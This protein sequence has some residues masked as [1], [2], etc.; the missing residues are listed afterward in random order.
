MCVW[1]GVCILLCNWS[2]VASACNSLKRGFGSW[3]EIAVWP[4]CWEHRILATRLV[5]SNKVL[6]LQLCKKGIPTKTERSETSQVLIRRRRV[7]YVRIDTGGL[8]ELHSRGSLNHFYGHFFQVS[9]GQS[10]FIFKYL[11]ICLCWVLVAA[12]RIFVAVRSK[13]H[14]LSSCS[15]WA[16]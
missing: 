12:C 5:V 10:F 13:A 15:L 11:F 2:S 8:G 9:F 1:G 7:Q 14:G 3:P 16:L 4:P 6:S